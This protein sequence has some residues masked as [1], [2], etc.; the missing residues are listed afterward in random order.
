MKMKTMTSLP[1]SSSHPSRAQEKNAIT[2][3]GFWIYLMSDTIIFACLFA[4]Y[5]VLHNSTFGG[6]GGREIFDLPFVLTET[7]LLLTS[8]FTAGLGTLAAQKRSKRGVLTWFSVSLVLGLTFLSL[9]MHEFG[10]LIAAGHGP[11]TS[12]FVSAYFALVGTHGLHVALGSLWMLVLLIHVARTAVTETM[13]RRLT[14]LALFWHFLD[15][16]WILIFTVV[17]LMAF[18]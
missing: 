1:S 14:M 11:S 15:I 12:A 10:A 18:V 16:I 17:Y 4:V 3:L 7:L 2:L 8:S 5:A 9:E 13:Q 6:P